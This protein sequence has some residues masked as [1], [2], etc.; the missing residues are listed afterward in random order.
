MFRP[1]GETMELHDYTQDELNRLLE[2][3]QEERNLA[4]ITLDTVDALVIVLDNKGYIVRFNK[5][6]EKLTGYSFEKVKGRHLAFLL[7]PKEKEG[8]LSLVDDLTRAIQHNHENFWVTKEGEQRLI[9]WKNSVLCDATGTVKYVIGTGIDVTEKKRVEE[10]LKQT[11]QELRDMLRQQQGVIFKVKK[12]A[13]AGFIHTLCEGD[14]LSELGLSPE[15]IMG[16]DLHGFLPKEIAEYARPFNEKAWSGE[17]TFYEAAFNKRNLMIT[18][19]PVFWDDKVVEL[20][21]YV[22]DITKLKVAEEL[23]R[24][25]EKMALVGQLAAGIA[26]EIRNPLTTIKG[27]IQLIGNGSIAEQNQKGYI[28]LTLSELDR[29]NQI[30]NEFLSVSNPQDLRLQRKEISSII[31][32]VTSLLDPQAILNKVQIWSHIAPDLPPVWCA[33][34]QMKQVFINIIK[35]AIEAMPDGGNIFIDVKQTDANYLSIRCTDEGCGIPKERIPYLGE[36]F[37]TLKEKGTGLGL[38]MCYRIIEAHQ[39][40]I[41]VTSQLN[42]GTAIDILL[43]LEPIAVSRIS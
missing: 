37:Y 18:L 43:P 9:S 38:M 14:L 11:Q 34:N 3:L 17:K 39:G 42:S 7:L 16:K 22:T 36:P 30:V 19:N 6:C 35:N 12:D 28:D 5:A 29:I 4:T 21:G 13:Q 20:V 10:Q 41:H 32:T 33:E 23:L 40:R 24:K 26:H 1:D 27:F 8:V 25:S 2:S 31:E 15:E